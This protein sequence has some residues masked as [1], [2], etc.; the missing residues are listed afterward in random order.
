MFI[1]SDPIT[2]PPLPPFVPFF[3]GGGG[4]GDLSVMIYVLTKF[5]IAMLMVWRIA[6][7]N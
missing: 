1:P 6:I 3:E 5:E 4:G 2:P 7:W